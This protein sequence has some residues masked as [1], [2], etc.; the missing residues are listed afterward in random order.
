MISVIGAGK[1]GSETA[2]VLA[3][4]G[5]DDIRLIDIVEG[6][7]QGHALDMMHASQSLR[8]EVSG[9]N[10]FQDLRGSDIV[11][12]TAGLPR[13]PGMLRTDLINKNR[14]ILESVARKIRQF[15]PESIVIQVSNPL[16]IMTYVMKRA[17][18]F[19]RE[20]V[21]G[22]G[23]LLD[24]QR[25]AYRLSRELDA[26]PSEI[27]ALVMGEHGE[28]MVPI[29]SKSIYQGKPVSGL[30][31]QEK[32]KGISEKTRL[33]GSEVIA[34]KGATVFSPAIATAR[35][36]E[37]ILRDGKET[38][39][40]SAYLE[41]EYGLEGLC[42]GVPAVL[43]KSGI[44]KIQELELSEEEEKAFRASAEKLKGIVSELGI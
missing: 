2:F 7:P 39:P 35:M 38:F 13:K 8:V 34:L 18:G 24:S 44:E 9:S 6:L 12:N 16:D 10:D 37:S 1:L 22:M 30:I 20:R 21:M 23:G 15:A 28:S 42:L 19:E 41:G 3:R 33:A 31:S 40:V 14:D 26:K 4:M 36:V 17:T 32:M 25:L 27:N 11:I 29:F 5:L 43:G